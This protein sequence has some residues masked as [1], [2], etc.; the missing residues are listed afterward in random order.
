MRS[1]LR[2]PSFRRLAGALAVSQPGDWLYNVALLAFVYD[3]THSATWVGVTT[4]VRVL[5][6]VVLGPLGGALADRYDRRRLMILADLGRAAVM[7]ACSAAPRPVHRCSCAG[8]G[9]PGH[10]ASGAVPAGHRRDHAATGRRRRP[11]PANAVRSVDRAGLH[12]RRPGA[13]RAGAGGRRPAAASP[14]R[15]DVRRLR[16]RCRRDPARPRR[17]VRRPPRADSAPRSVAS[18]RRSTRPVGTGAARG[19][20]APTS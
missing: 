11:G 6:V 14:E 19:S 20:S 18:Y 15:R 17:S 12:R 4:A 7:L 10:R 5:P 13:G 2:S 3:R 1:A 16:G 8:A 9:R